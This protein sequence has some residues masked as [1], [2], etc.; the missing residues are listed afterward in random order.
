MSLVV[1]YRGTEPPEVAASLPEDFAGGADR[2][3]L[4]VTAFG[5]G[6]RIGRDLGSGQ[7]WCNPE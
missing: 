1:P 3:E 7:V 5:K 2:V 4:G 6:W